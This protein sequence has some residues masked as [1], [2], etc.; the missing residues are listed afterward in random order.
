MHR[1]YSD[2]NYFAHFQGDPHNLGDVVKFLTQMFN[3]VR[4]CPDTA[5]AQARDLPIH[6]MGATNFM[7]TKSVFGYVAEEIL[8]SCGYNLM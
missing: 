6:S 5:S 2:D 3:S 8:L 4:Y 1:Q 7:F